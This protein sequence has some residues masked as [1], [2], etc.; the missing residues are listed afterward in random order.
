[1]IYIFKECQHSTTG[2]SALSQQLSEDDEDS[3]SKKPSIDSL[4]H[5]RDELLDILMER[6]RDINSFTRAAALRVWSTLLENEAI[7]VNRI[8]SVAEV[9]VDRLYDKTAVVRKGAI[10]LITCLLD[11]NPFS[12][13][14]NA[15][16]YQELKYKLESALA[17]RMD[18]IRASLT[19]AN[20]SSSSAR[21]LSSSV[22]AT[23]EGEDEGNEVD[24]KDDEG[25]DD[26]VAESEEEE[27]DDELEEEDMTAFTNDTEIYK[28]TTE[29]SKCH[30]CLELLQS[31]NTAIPAIHQMLASKTTSDVIEALKFFTRAMNFGINGS[32]TCLLGSFSLIWHQDESIQTECLTAF[33]NVFITDGTSTTASIVHSTSSSEAT[34]VLPANE[35]ARNFVTLAQRLVAEFSFS[36]IVSLEKIISEVFKRKLVTNS[37]DVISALW[38]LVRPPFSL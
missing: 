36:E 10:G 28:L 21:R 1:V 20:A 13:D 3:S 29:L 38:H 12:G 6:V 19:S 34:K 17:K 32:A 8:G 35:I 33:L 24:E 4:I 22:L 14:L 27:E 18:T 26:T 9:G 23:Q 5:L 25:D 7:P 31:I 37:E 15:E 16:H 11:Y 2:A 30:S